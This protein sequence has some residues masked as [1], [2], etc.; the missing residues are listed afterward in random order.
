MD[1]IF[2]VLAE[3][4]KP[5]CGLRP[6][7]YP[8]VRRQRDLQSRTGNDLPIHHNRFLSNA[9]N[10]QDRGFG[11]VDDGNEMVNLEHAQVGDRES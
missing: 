10:G 11:R 6:V 8:V 7:C 9:A 4:L 3:D 5:A 2:N 1:R